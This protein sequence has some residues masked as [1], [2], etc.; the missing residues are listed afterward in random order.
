MRIL[1]CVKV[2]DFVA[3]GQEIAKIIEEKEEEYFIIDEVN[4]ENIE[5]AEFIN[6]CI[7]VE[8]ARNEFYDYRYSIQKVEEVAVRA[9]SPGV[10]DPYTAIE[11]INSMSKSIRKLADWN[12][13]YY[14]LEKD[15]PPATLYTKSISF[16]EDLYDFFSEIILYG[17]SDLS[18]IKTLFNAY[19]T[20]SSEA[21]KENLKA[22]KGIA[23]YTYEKSK[24]NFTHN[25]DKKFIDKQ[26]YELTFYL[27]TMN[28][29]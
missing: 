3:K 9:L 21:S 1:V 26:Y 27:E 29:K 7:T 20:I 6:S 24:E 14:I 15:D 19:K 12:N 17:A 11:C 10:N 22:I 18:V 4:E 5:I 28:D 16:E 8:Y 2:G 23:E 25:K 13:G